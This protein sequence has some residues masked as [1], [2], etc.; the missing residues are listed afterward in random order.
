[1][2][3]NDECNNSDPDDT[4]LRLDWRTIIGA[5]IVAALVVICALGYAGFWFAG[6]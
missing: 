2:N 5:L 1:M 4:R 3:D 6:G